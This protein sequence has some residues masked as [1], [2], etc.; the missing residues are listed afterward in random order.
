M[1]KMGCRVKG[2]LF[3]IVEFGISL[4]FNR[5]DLIESELLK[6]RRREMR[7]FQ[8]K[9]MVRGECCRLQEESKNSFGLVFK[10]LNDLII[11]Y[12]CVFSYLCEKESWVINDY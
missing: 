1:V 4:Y 6:I 12:F 2:E 3:K 7:Y 10:E 5:D 9:G 8:E 11:Y